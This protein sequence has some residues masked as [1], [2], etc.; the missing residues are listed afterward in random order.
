MNLESYN[1]KKITNGGYDYYLSNKTERLVKKTVDNNEIE[2]IGGTDEISSQT[3]TVKTIKPK[4]I[5]KVLPKESQVKSSEKIMKKNSDNVQDDLIAKDK[6]QINIF[7]F[8]Y[9]KLM[10]CLTVVCSILSIYFTGTYLQRLQSAI[11]AYAIS[12][13]MLIY[14]LVGSQMTKRAWYSKRYLQ[15]IIFG[16]TTTC[17]IA[18]SMLSSIDVNYAKYKARH[19]VMEESYNVDDGKKLSFS[20]LKDELAEN[21][22]LIE[23]LNADSKF[24]QTQYVMSWDNSLHK[25]VLLDGQITKTA[26]E[27]IKEN[28][29]KIKELNERN[30]EI[31]EK[32]MKYAESGVSMTTNESKTDKAKSLTD[33]VGSMLNISGNVIQLIFLLV[34][35]VFID[36]IGVLSLSIYNGKFEKEKKKKN[37]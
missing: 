14:G 26:Q 33:L 30:K 37:K 22:K 25:N 18:F 16:I 1:L 28:D 17:T 29:G 15:A 2:I 10:L 27:K 21:K 7:D 34:P 31:N 6:K 5:K 13:A 23:V 35:S 24:Q 8:V 9:P 12:T 19:Q 20:L 32:L 3:K 4:K 11:I 36:I